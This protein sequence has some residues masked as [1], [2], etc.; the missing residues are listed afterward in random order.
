M[1]SIRFTEFS[2]LD[3]SDPKSMR[4]TEEEFEQ[5]I[6]VPRAKDKRELPLILF[7]E[8]G[9][10]KTSKGSYRHDGNLLRLT[11]L[12]IDHDSGSLPFS[13]A[14]KLIK[15]LGVRAFV[16]T[17]SSHNRKSKSNPSGGPRWHAFFP[18]RHPVKGIDQIRLVT[19]NWFHECAFLDPSHETKVLSQAF[20]IGLE[21]SSKPME[22][23]H[24]A[25][26]SYIDDM[27]DLFQ[28]L[29]ELEEEEFDPEPE[30]MDW[31]RNRKKAISLLNKVD[32]DV[33]YMDWYRA[34]GAA[35]MMGAELEDVIL[36]SSAGSK[37]KSAEEVE[38]KFNDLDRKEAERVAGP[39]TLHHLAK[40]FP[41][42]DEELEE[43]KA[44]NE[45]EGLKALPEDGIPKIEPPEYLVQGLIARGEA[46]QLIGQGGI[47]KSTLAMLLSVSVCLGIPFLGTFW[48]KQS[49][50]LYVSGED[51]ER[52]FLSR[53]G[54]ICR[55][56]KLTPKQYA[57]LQKNF[58]WMDLREKGSRKFRAL[59]KP[60]ASNNHE[61]TEGPLAK[62]LRKHAAGYGLVILD[63]MSSITAGEEN[64]NDAMKR[65]AEIARDV[66]DDTQAAV[67]IVHHTGKM[68]KEYSQHSG[69]GA[70]AQA[71]GSRMVLQVGVVRQREVLVDGI[72]YMAP[73]TLD[74]TNK[75]LDENQV[76]LF[77]NLKQTWTKRSSTPLFIL[78][79]GFNFEADWGIQEQ[80]DEEDEE[81]S[82]EIRVL[83]YIRDNPDC[84]F[85]TLSPAFKNE[86]VQALVKTL[87]AEG[88]IRQTNA[89]GP[90]TF[91]ITHAGK[92]RI[93]ESY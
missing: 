44:A 59:M 41:M 56:L 54:E 4:M 52:G 20:F 31:T 16:H 91:R 63:P 81:P 12:K 23:Y 85:K 38:Q 32:P 3:G 78:R 86:P 89:K 33:S 34:M 51:G 27:L 77:A 57:T 79:D 13:Q 49:P 60:S 30:E 47:G 73:E 9:K 21:D 62:V 72:K 5:Y 83:E 11:G 18:L 35:K 55:A 22:H 28:E 14:V 88:M 61:F 29:P 36:W 64:S 40:E 6:Q 87:M 66:A 70:S 80:R 65:L 1:S 71:D 76:M 68:V 2:S 8:F 50:V 93:S 75:A 84:G 24:H 58:R 19:E 42:V 39:G 37:F 53:M 69:R 15:K 46:G 17:T 92:E 67:L 90:Q 26:D 7:G 10:N 25:S 82:L 74:I 48:T 43:M 45:F